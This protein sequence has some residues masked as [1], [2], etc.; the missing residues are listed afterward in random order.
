MKWGM[1]VLRYHET[2]LTYLDLYPLIQGLEWC[3]LCTIWW[4]D[5][6]IKVNED[7]KEKCSILGKFKL[8]R[9]IYLKMEFKNSLKVFFCHKTSTQIIVIDNTWPMQIC[10]FERKKSA[11]A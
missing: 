8:F 4:K 9:G 10:V 6:L 11:S 7:F 3:L 5:L 1:P 2:S